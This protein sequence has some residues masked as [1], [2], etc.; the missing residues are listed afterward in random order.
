MISFKDFVQEDGGINWDAYNE[1]GKNAGERCVKCN[2]VITYPK[3]PRSL[4]VMCKSI[5]DDAEFNHDVFVRC[6]ECRAT[7][8]VNSDCDDGEIYESGY[9][10]IDC[11]E[12]E[13]EFDF[14]TRISFSFAS[15]KM[16]EK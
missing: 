16:G 3:A 1:A 13:T 7:Q 6:P 2:G 10:T 15:P 14:E 9:H 11:S 4:C 12:C 8:N 5:D